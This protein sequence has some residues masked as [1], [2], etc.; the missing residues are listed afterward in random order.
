M[1]CNVSDFPSA[2]IPSRFLALPLAWCRSAEPGFKASPASAARSL[3]RTMQHVRK[4]KAFYRI[5]IWIVGSDRDRAVG[6]PENLGVVIDIGASPADGLL[7]QIS[8]CVTR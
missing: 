6:L 1:A 4:V 5:R 8:V 3:F 2:N 7:E